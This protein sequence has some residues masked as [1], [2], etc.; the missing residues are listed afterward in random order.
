MSDVAQL[1]ATVAG[2]EEAVARLDTTVALVETG[3]AD[4]AE[5]LYMTSTVEQVARRSPNLAS[6]IARRR[7]AV[8]AARGDDQV[9][10]R[11]QVPRNYMPVF[12]ADMD[13]A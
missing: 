4:L 9:E 13:A 3:L 6:V 11:P 8:A 5:S 10:T 12:N 7:L 1:E 2:L